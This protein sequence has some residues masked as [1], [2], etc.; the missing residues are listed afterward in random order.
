MPLLD[1]N[2]TTPSETITPDTHDVIRLPGG[3]TIA[4]PKF[5]DADEKAEIA[6]HAAHGTDEYLQRSAPDAPSPQ[7]GGDDDNSNNNS[8]FWTPERK[9]ETAALLGESAYDGYST[10]K[11]IGRG[12][13]EN[14]PIAAPLVKKGPAGQAAASA[15]GPAAVVGI[16]YL[17]HK[18]G[19]DKLADWIGRVTTS[20]E[21][22]NDVRQYRVLKS[23]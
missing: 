16:E 6:A 11:I 13:V 22:A 20:A 8:K 17:A 7:N 1:N 15:L 19:H 14:D 5:M 12:G 4:V 10:Q 21:G 3:S 23:K 9:A 18:L 2:S